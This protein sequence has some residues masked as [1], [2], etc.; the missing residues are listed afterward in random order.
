MST[1]SNTAR[2]RVVIGK[3]A[4]IPSEEIRRLP[5]VIEMQKRAADIVAKYKCEHKYEIIGEGS[6]CWIMKCLKCG[7]FKQ[8][9]Y[10]S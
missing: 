2:I 1:V 3:G 6:F 5:E 8:G 9:A 10:P 4:F 7:A